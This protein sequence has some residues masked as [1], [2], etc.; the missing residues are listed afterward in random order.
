MQKHGD[1]I[2]RIIIL[3][4][5]LICLTL[6]H[7][8]DWDND[9]QVFN[10]IDLKDGSLK[11]QKTFEMWG[12]SSAADGKLII[13][14]GDGNTIIAEASPEGFKPITEASI[15][16][17]ADNSTFSD[18]RKCFCWTYPVLSHGQLYLRNSHGN[19]ICVNMK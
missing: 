3:A 12:A 6:V 14:T 8:D 18:R 11:W 17:M 2:A 1:A 16:P 19:L 9:K 15:I 7:A 13:V 10:C 4:I 5:S